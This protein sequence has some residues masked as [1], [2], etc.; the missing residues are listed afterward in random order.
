MFYNEVVPQT[1][2]WKAIAINLDVNEHDIERI[3]RECAGIIQD[4]FLKVLDIWKRRGTP[5]FTL[6]TMLSALE[7]NS[8][9]EFR[10][11]QALREKYPE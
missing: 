9:G 1:N 4:C 10:L 6:K 7:E 2:Q 5:L 11:A 8:V 3:E